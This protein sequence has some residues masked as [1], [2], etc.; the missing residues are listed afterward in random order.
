VENRVSHRELETGSGSGN[1]SSMNSSLSLIDDEKSDTDGVGDSTPATG[2]P[3]WSELSCFASPSEAFFPRFPSQASPHGERMRPVIPDGVRHGVGVDRGT[4]NRPP[5]P[6]PTD[7]CVDFHKLL[8]QLCAA[9]CA[10]KASQKL[11]ERNEHVK[12][13]VHSKERGKIASLIRRLKEKCRGKVL[14]WRRNSH[15]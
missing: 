12:E 15:E 5:S 8:H 9:K 3:Q 11:H 13:Q 6:I 2:D 7:G 14:R 10:L 1:N 4:T